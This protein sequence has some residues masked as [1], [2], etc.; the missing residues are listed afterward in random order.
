M[1]DTVGAV[2]LVEPGDFEMMILSY[3]DKLFFDGRPAAH[4][5]KLFASIC[6]FLPNHAK[7]AGASFPRI[8]RALRGW[9]KA[10]PVQSRLPLPWVL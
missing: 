7:G 1:Q 2:L 3:M 6:F 10:V 9:R 8:P 4:G 5:E